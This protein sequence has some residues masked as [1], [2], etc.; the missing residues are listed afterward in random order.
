MIAGNPAGACIQKQLNIF[1]GTWPL[2]EGEVRNLWCVIR[3]VWAFLIARLIHGREQF[4][5]I[6]FAEPALTVVVVMWPDGQAASTI[7]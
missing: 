2:I 1:I 3:R 4:V 5:G 6:V 7:P